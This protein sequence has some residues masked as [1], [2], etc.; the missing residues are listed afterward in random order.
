[1]TDIFIT[2]SD[3][4]QLGEIEHLLEIGD[5]FEISPIFHFID[6]MS[7]KG[8]KESISLKSHWAARLDPFV[9]IMDGDKAIKAFYSETGNNVI[10]SLI[11][12]LTKKNENISDR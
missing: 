1:M 8:R 5:I 4:A 3:K 6:S 10:E 7:K 11:N 12:Y 2:Y 9:L